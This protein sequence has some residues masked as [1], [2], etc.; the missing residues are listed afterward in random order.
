MAVAFC[1]E[2][3]A[4]SSPLETLARCSDTLS[5]N[6]QQR[7][8]IDNS[9]VGRDSE[10]ELRQQVAMQEK[11]EETAIDQELLLTV[12]LN[13]NGRETI[14]RIYKE[15]TPD[16]V[17]DELCRREVFGFDKPSLDSCI[18]QVGYIPCDWTCPKI[19]GGNLHLSD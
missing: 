9:P 15:S 16:G 6:I 4:P 11:Q 2:Y 12:P 5:A 14:L 7:L 13:I 10:T 8:G 18:H 17:A 3:L 1:T 19:A